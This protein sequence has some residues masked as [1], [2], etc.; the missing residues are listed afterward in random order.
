LRCVPVPRLS[1]FRVGLQFTGSEI[2]AFSSSGTIALFDWDSTNSPKEIDSNWESHPATVGYIRGNQS[3]G[4]TSDT[5]QAIFNSGTPDGAPG[6]ELG[7]IEYFDGGSPQNPTSSQ[8]APTSRAQQRAINPT[9]GEIDSRFS[10]WLTP[11]GSVGDDK[12]SP[13]MDLG[14]PIVATPFLPG[15]PWSP[16]NP[17]DPD[18]ANLLGGLGSDVAQL[19]LGSLGGNYNNA[20]PN[21]WAQ[22]Q[23]QSLGAGGAATSQFAWNVRHNPMGLSAA[24]IDLLLSSDATGLIHKYFDGRGGNWSPPTDPTEDMLDYIQTGLGI[25]GIADPTPICDGINTAISLYR[26]NYADAAINAAGM[27]PYVGDAAKAARLAGKPGKL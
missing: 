24:Q 4:G 26:G 23:S 18:V 19:G 5:T 21:E 25:G 17:L 8:P 11:A 14:S 15:V 22:S 3:S 7:N 13:A 27:I 16:G 9:G 6:E 12:D 20:G 1:L 10:G 2:Q